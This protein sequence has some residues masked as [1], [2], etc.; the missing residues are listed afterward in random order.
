MDGKKKQS[1]GYTA[2]LWKKK[3]IGTYFSQSLQFGK[4]THTIEKLS[5]LC[6]DSSF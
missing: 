5:L 4:T 1:K 2:E 3:S 6:K